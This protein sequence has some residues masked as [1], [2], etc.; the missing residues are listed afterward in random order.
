MCAVSIAD[1]VREGEGCP[2]IAG[3]GGYSGSQTVDAPPETIAG[4][5]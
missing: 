2:A 3:L 4:L 5:T 1:G